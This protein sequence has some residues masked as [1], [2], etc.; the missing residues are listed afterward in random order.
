MTGRI[1]L[2]SEY[3]INASMAIRQISSL[4]L[5]Q[6]P[7]DDQH[8]GQGQQRRDHERPPDR[9]GQVGLVDIAVLTW[10]SSCKM[11]SSK[12]AGSLTAA[13]AAR[14][15]TA[16]KRRPG[17]PKR[18]GRQPGVERLKQPDH[19]ARP[20]PLAHPLEAAHQVGIVGPGQF[21]QVLPPPGP[22]GLGQE[23]CAGHHDEYADAQQAPPRLGTFPSRV[24]HRSLVERAGDGGRPSRVLRQRLRAAPA[25]QRD[26]RGPARCGQ[27]DAPRR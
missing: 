16:T 8:N 9:Q 25:E 23:D 18:E 19:R 26:Q 7:A 4:R 21:G 11:T 24:T 2:R 10:A 27:V 1:A 20:G 6:H 12:A 17:R 15:L 5:A 14:A 3:T 22:P 13:T